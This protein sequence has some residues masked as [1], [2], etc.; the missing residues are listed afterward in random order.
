[1]RDSNSPPLDCQSN[2][3]ARWANTPRNNNDA[4]IHRK[5]IIQSFWESFFSCEQKILFITFA[6]KSYCCVKLLTN[7]WP[8]LIAHNKQIAPTYHKSGLPK[9]I[10]LKFLWKIIVV[11]MPVHHRHNNNHNSYINTRSNL[12]VQT[13]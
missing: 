7:S 13:T 6:S 5:S 1:M 11:S 8:S 10:N 9:F 2:A 12:I 3:L 4:K